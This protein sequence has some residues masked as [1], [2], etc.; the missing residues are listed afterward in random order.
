MYC[1]LLKG[2]YSYLGGVFTDVLGQLG[3]ALERKYSV[4]AMAFG[5]GLGPYPDLNSAQRLAGR[6]KKE[7]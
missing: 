5:I 3:P 2:A 4:F 1:S 6:V 7:Y